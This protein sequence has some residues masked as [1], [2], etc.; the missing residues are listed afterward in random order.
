MGVLSVEI[1]GELR[2]DCLTLFSQCD[3]LSDPDKFRKLAFSFE[4]LKLVRGCIPF[5][6]ELDHEMLIARL[7]AT[8]RP[9]MEPAL[10]DLL[11]F[12]GRRLSERND[13]KAPMC[14]E[15]KERLRAEL[16]QAGGG[17][18]ARDYR[19]VV[20]AGTRGDVRESDV[21]G[22]QWIEAAGDDL[23]DLALRVTLAVFNGTTF[24]VIE[25]AKGRLL[26]MLRELVPP[27]PPPLAPAEGVTP[28]APP[29]HVPIVRRL[30]K[31]GARETEGRPPDWRRVIEL[32]RPEL[33]GDAL[34][35]VWEFYREPEWRRKLIE[36][37]TNHAVGHA[38]DVRTR[39]AVA[40]GRLALRDYRYVK[41]N[42]LRRW[43]DASE[44][45][46]DE[47]PDGRKAAQY[48]MAV[49]MA[50]GVLA[51][52]ENWIGEVENLLGQWSRSS[53]RAERWAAVRAYIYA[54]PYC[55]PISGVIR[56]L[57]DIASS[58]PYAVY[59]P[60]PGNKIL[61]V[62]NPIYMSL[63]DAMVQFF[64]GVAQQPVE[65]RRQS[66]AGILEGLKE[67]IAAERG[68]A[69]TGLFMFSTLGRLAFAGTDGESSGSSPPLLLQLV[70][71]QPERTDYR[72][73]LAGL[74]E[75]TLRDATTF[76]EARELLCVWAS[77]V[78]GLGSNSESYEARMRVL[79]S[80]IIRAD[81]SGRMRGRL[82]AC[83]RYCGRNRVVERILATL[84][85]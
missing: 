20:E 24:E 75:L 80:D 6:R 64:A 2:D 39:A 85:A 36:W 52:E 61:E 83:L 32:D 63:L 38:A 53:R 1:S 8:G 50:L 77:W 73:Q 79:L 10:L 72:E 66:F 82:A 74:F 7:L 23:D 31:A 62:R 18:Q 27:P 65:A 29:P 71:E 22:R 59:L 69:G 51:R 26:E 47:E 16:Q 14:A 55:R 42:V 11:E 84:P 40:V 78:N 35:H 41:D 4:E 30:E 57:R 46:P 33:G 68:D 12:L 67:W 76:L 19:Q 21:S 44:K 25:R 34:W 17:E 37:L 81:K 58:E 60:V 15:L 45:P 70:E 43:V 54:G 28:A 56:R 48:R 13:M 49:G 9:P 5:A 3:E